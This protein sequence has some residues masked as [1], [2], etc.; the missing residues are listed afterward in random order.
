[1]VSETSNERFEIVICTVYVTR[2]I[3]DSVVAEIRESGG[4]PLPSR[5]CN[6]AS[7]LHE[8]EPFN[9]TGH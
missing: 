9:R 3:A 6:S 2:C 4:K 7:L 1:M 5:D 8:W